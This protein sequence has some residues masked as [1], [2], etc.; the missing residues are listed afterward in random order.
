ME[1]YVCILAECGTARQL[2][3]G[4]K[5]DFCQVEKQVYGNKRLV[6]LFNVKLN[7]KVGL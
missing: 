3:F 5:T 2:Q 6:C 4:P 1:G 7:S